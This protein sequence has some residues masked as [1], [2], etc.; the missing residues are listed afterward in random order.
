MNL[1]RRDRELDACGIGFVADAEGRSSRAI[2]TSA[3]RGLANVKHRGAVAADARS[4]DGSGLL[5]PIPPALFGAGH[6]V[7]TVFARGSDPRRTVE[8]AATSEGVE[9]VDWRTPPTDDDHLGDLARDSKPEI[10]QAVMARSTAATEGAPSDEDERVAY[11][12]RRR[13]AA[14]VADVYIASCSFSTNGKPPRRNGSATRGTEKF[15]K[16]A[17]SLSGFTASIPHW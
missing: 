13:I 16:N 3:L 12:L 8:A 4:G 9:I 15:G 6:G 10:L 17:G 11:R 1:H 2:V 5:T 7:I 14:E